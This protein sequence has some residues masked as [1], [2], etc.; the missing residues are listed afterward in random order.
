MKEECFWS[1][2]VE[3]DLVQAGIWA[4]RG[5]NV[6]ILATSEAAK[7]ETDEDLVEKTDHALSQAIENFPEEER[8]PE[9]TVFGV[10][11]SWVEDGKIKKP[12]LEKIRLISQK[13]SLSPTGFVVLPEAIAH[14]VKVREG[15]PLSGVVIG[16]GV[17]SLD[18]TV[19]RLGNIVGTVSVGRSASVVEDVVEGL[20]RFSVQDNVPTRWLLYDGKEVDLEDVKQEL[21]KTDWA[22][23]GPNLKFLHTPQIEIVDTIQ[24]TEA[25]S[26]AGA[27]ELGEVKGVEGG[28]SSLEDNNLSAT[29]E[30]NPEDLGFVVDQGI[31]DNTQNEAFAQHPSETYHTDS[32]KNSPLSKLSALLAGIPK[33]KS[34]LLNSKGEPMGTKSHLSKKRTLRVVGAFAVLLV[35]AMGAAWFYFST[36]DI[37]IYIAPKSLGESEA[38]VLDQN[39]TSPD[40]DN[41]TFPARSVT[42][43]VT[44]EKSKPATGSKTVGDAAKGKVTIR[45]GTASEVEFES[46][47]TLVGPNSLEFTLDEAVT[48]PEA[49]SPSSPGEVSVGVTAS[50]IGEGYNLAS[51]ESFSVDNYPKSEVDAVSDGEITG[52]TSREA[53]VVSESD[54]DILTEELTSELEDQASTQLE[55]EANGARFVSEAVTYDVIDESF[56]VQAGEEANEVRLT[57]TMAAEG[58]VLPEE[59]VRELSEL[60]LKDQVPQGF[61]LRSE[62]VVTQFDLIDET[63]E[64]TWELDVNLTANLL[65]SINVDEVKKEVAGKHPQ[66]VEKYLSSIPGYVRATIIRRPKLPGFLGNLPRRLKNISIEIKAEL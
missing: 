53:T 18:L 63:G 7:W 1:I 48:V 49:S 14:S 35:V 45:N 57:M 13:L 44:S 51:G 50:Q 2:V 37:V 15:S 9:K 62:Q 4:I 47:T 36:A 55:A 41:F 61:S 5:E 29:S 40:P 52:G 25:V 34:K 27:S 33:L 21:V 31:A 20:M 38:I 39:I 28:K 54:I 59:Q 65:P 24:K 46:G 60:I 23:S 16:V 32:P 19:F 26:I 6:V 64:G 58:I 66:N 11:A 10:P 17:G 43:E 30:L 42:T 56:S 12:H 8:E 3:Q 22:E